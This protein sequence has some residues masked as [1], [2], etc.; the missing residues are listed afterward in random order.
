MKR[1]LITLAFVVLFAGL[2]VMLFARPNMLLTAQGAG[3]TVTPTS[4]PIAGSNPIAILPAAITVTLDTNGGTG[5]IV[6]ELGSD[7]R[8]GPD[9][10]IP[11]PG[12]YCQHSFSS[13]A[14]DSCVAAGAVGMMATFHWCSLVDSNRVYHFDAVEDWI[15]ANEAAGLRSIISFALK[16]L[17]DDS[18]QSSMSCTPGSQGSPYWAITGI[19]NDDIGGVPAAPLQNPTGTYHL[20]FLDQQAAQQIDTFFGAVGTWLTQYSIGHP[21]MYDTIEAITT[22][23]LDSG[24]ASYYSWHPYSN[25]EMYVCRY[26][27]AS[28]DLSKAQGDPTLCSVPWNTTGWVSVRIAA[29]A[30][31][32]DFFLVPF[33]SRYATSIPL[34]RKMINV[35]N[36]LSSPYIEHAEDSQY[37]PG[38]IG[39]IERAHDLGVG[40]YSSGGNMDYGN[41]NGSDRAGEELR[42]FW[43]AF[44]KWRT[45][46]TPLG[47]EAGALFGTNQGLP[48]CCDTEQE[49]YWYW[50]QALDTG[51][52]YIL[53]SPTSLQALANTSTMSYINLWGPKTFLSTY[54]GSSEAIG[55]WMRDTYG[56]YYPEGDNY[57]M[58]VP[59]SPRS[60]EPWCCGNQPNREFMMYQRNAS[61]AQVV[62]TGLPSGA[63]Q[64][65]VARTTVRGGSQIGN[66]D[67]QFD[68]QWALC[69]S[70]DYWLRIMFLSNG[71]TF[72]VF[73][74]N[75]SGT[76]SYYAV[77]KGNTGQWETAARELTDI[78][79]SAYM[80]GN[81]S[82]R[83]FDANDGADVFHSI[84][85]Q[86]APGCN[87]LPTATPTA[88][89]TVT[90][91]ATPT[92]TPTATPTAT[93][94]W[95]PGGE[96][97]TPTST[98]SATPTFTATWTP[99]A[100]PTRTPTR[101]PTATPRTPTPIPACTVTPVNMY[102]DVEG[103]PSSPT[104]TGT[105]TVPATALP[106]YTPTITPTA[107]VTPTATRTPTATPTD[108]PTATS[109]PA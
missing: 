92:W 27:G 26:G 90:P 60:E 45:D 1:S 11:T 84:V 41:G 46:N 15:A 6:G 103:P 72:G 48:G 24:A 25:R 80:N 20:N 93:P 109:T 3:A 14:R 67:F 88:T 82:V 98:A 5:L 34:Q 102:E 71:G 58:G 23:E 64:S 30:R 74:P 91:T 32:R 53:N 19:Y 44:Y 75:T 39:L 49:L 35:S 95:T 70:T 101:T 47:A 78:D 17:P 21:S 10:L 94:T 68:P 36:A 106:T 81:V 57:T 33:L 76:I 63:R 59:S 66:L 8:R 4:T 77:P 13:A 42:N 55:V 54:P 62:S 2:A 85:L 61:P 73:Y 31:W 79:P 28:W 83:L 56:N 40:L 29:S 69:T 9:A 96:T 107:T 38:T 52:K 104:P 22:E 37:I 86:R 65:F 12:F 105:A 89:P 87:L 16:D 18:P 51:A 97:A 7:L 99:T 43:N 108:T 100:T 50:L